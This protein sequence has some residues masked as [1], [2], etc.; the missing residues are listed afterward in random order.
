MLT[1]QCLEIRRGRK[2]PFLHSFKCRCVGEKRVR[3]RSDDV[4]RHRPT[5]RM[6]MTANDALKNEESLFHLRRTTMDPTD[7]KV[8]ELKPAKCSGTNSV[9][10][11]AKMALQSGQGKNGVNC[12]G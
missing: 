3:Q 7:S 4:F 1:C 5:K 8:N 10:S 6:K 12:D 9:I 2:E 11:F